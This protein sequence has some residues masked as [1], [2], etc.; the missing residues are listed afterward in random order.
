M[1]FWSKSQSAQSLHDEGVAR[2]DAGEKD[3]ALTK[4]LAALKLD[5]NRPDTLC[6]IAGPGIQVPCLP[7]V[8]SR[9]G[10]GNRPGGDSNPLVPINEF[11]ECLVGPL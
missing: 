3:A 9:P 7:N 4:Y 10:H 11:F 1:V 6:N 2:S 8:P 5:P